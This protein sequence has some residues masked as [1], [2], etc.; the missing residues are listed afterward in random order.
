MDFERNRI[1][2]GNWLEVLPL[3]TLAI[4]DLVFADLTYN[5]QLENVLHRPDM[6]RVEGVND[7]YDIFD[8]FKSYD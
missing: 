4:V 2:E 1:I 5:L 6:T 3:L 8:D 7:K